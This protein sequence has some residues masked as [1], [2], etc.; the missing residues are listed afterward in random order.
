MMKK[1][2]DEYGTYPNIPNLRFMV[3]PQ[4]MH[5]LIFKTLEEWQG[6]DIYKKFGFP[7]SEDQFQWSDVEGEPMA[8]AKEKNKGSKH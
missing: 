3:T 8:A 1:N 4:L 7:G 5:Q 6:V 2:P